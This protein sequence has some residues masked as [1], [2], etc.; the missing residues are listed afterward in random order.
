VHPDP[1]HFPYSAGQQIAFD[2]FRTPAE[3]VGSVESGGVDGGGGG[4]GGG[5]ST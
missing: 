4:G 3:H 5:G 2:E 1:P